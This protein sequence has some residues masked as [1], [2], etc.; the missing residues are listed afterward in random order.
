MRQN[1]SNSDV[2]P[3]HH[4]IC[5]TA[6]VQRNKSLPRYFNYGPEGVNVCYPPPHWDEVK[7]THEVHYIPGR[8]S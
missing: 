1:N 2:P 4:C 7:C 5:G 3:I 8:V 6:W